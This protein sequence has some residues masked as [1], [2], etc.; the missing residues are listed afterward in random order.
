MKINES[1]LRKIISESIKK[2]LKESDFD[3][4][5]DYG[6]NKLLYRGN[7]YEIIVNKDNTMLIL[8]FDDSYLVYDNDG[9]WYDSIRGEVIEVPKEVFEYFGGEGIRLDEKAIN[10]IT[11]FVSQLTP[12]SKYVNRE[13]YI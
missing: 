11:R 7:G 1:Q 12:G 2:I 4:Q 9:E 6:D 8:Q 10:I 3:N 5:S 13:F